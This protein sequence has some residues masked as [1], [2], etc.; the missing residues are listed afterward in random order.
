VIFRIVIAEQFV[1]LPGEESPVVA[2]ALVD[3]GEPEQPRFP[4][5][6]EGGQRDLRSKFVPLWR[7]A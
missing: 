1:P 5:I 6:N 3:V 7:L 2:R 4:W